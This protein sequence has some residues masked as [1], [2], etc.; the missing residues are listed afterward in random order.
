MWEKER[1]SIDDPVSSSVGPGS[2]II[3]A[4]MPATNMGLSQPMVYP[5]AGNIQASPEQLDVT[6]ING[7]FYEPS[8]GLTFLHR[9]YKRLSTQRDEFIPSGLLES[10][11][12][13]PM[14]QA[15]DRPFVVDTINS[16]IHVPERRLAR[17]LIAFY[18]EHCTVTYLL[19][20]RNTTERWLEMMQTNVEAKLHPTHGLG[21]ARAA[22]VLTCLGIAIFRREKVMKGSDANYDETEAL[23]HSDPYVCAAINLSDSEMGYPKLESAQ[24]RILQALYLLQSSRMSKAWFTFGAATQISAVIELHRKQGRVK[25]QY[26][27]ITAQCRKRTFWVAYTIDMYLSVVFGRPRHFHDE[28]IDQEFPDSVNDEDMTPSGPTAQSKMYDDS[29]IDGVILHAK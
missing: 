19:L 16:A 1:V 21:N 29:Y 8:S 18:F 11:S 10:E 2:A 9:A 12:H 28:D 3:P 7:Q 22:V 27:Y 23:R 24:A 25:A 4:A 26:D 14:M 17:E 5:P 13:Q 15:G 20:H 6:E